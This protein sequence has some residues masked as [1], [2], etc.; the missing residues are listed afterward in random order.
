[1]IKIKLWNYQKLNN[2]T[3]I[4]S[5]TGEEYSCALLDDCTITDPVIKM[6]FENADYVPSFNY[7]HLEKF[8]RYYFINDWQFVRGLWYAYMSEDVLASFKTQIGAST[9]YVT[10]SASAYDGN[11]I[12]TEYPCLN[13]YV[14]YTDIL[15]LWNIPLQNLCDFVVNTIGQQRHTYLM[16]YAQFTALCDAMF[17]EIYNDDAVWGGVD[18]GIKMSM[19]NPIKYITSVFA[20]REGLIDHSGITAVT[21]DIGPITDALDSLGTVTAYPLSANYEVNDY[22]SAIRSHPQA[23]RGSYLNSAPTARYELMTPFGVYELNNSA[24]QM[25]RAKGLSIKTFFDF[26]TGEYRILAYISTGSSYYNGSIALDV[27]GQFGVPV[28]MMQSYTDTMASISSGLSAAGNLL[29]FNWGAAMQDIAN[30]AS[31][32]MTPVTSTVGT[33]GA[34]IYTTRGLSVITTFIYVADEDRANRG[35]PL[36]KTRQISTLS[37]YLE[38]SEPHFTSERANATELARINQYLTGGI[39]YE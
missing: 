32:G 31:A 4:P 30:T 14:Q 12:D 25:D 2:S 19:Y 3:S 38:C 16:T 18:P 23:S 17:N 29:S 35:R 36:M 33:S 9:Q 7:A 24:M 10:R 15:D 37:G 26:Q 22:A 27:S 5:V 1:M 39:Y 13:K 28:Q 8:D 11:V 20:V 21:P 34:S 6:N